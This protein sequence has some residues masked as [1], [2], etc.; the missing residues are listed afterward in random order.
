[1]TPEQVMERE[2]PIFEGLGRRVEMVDHEVLEGGIACV[3]YDVHSAHGVQR[4]LA[5]GQDG[6]VVTSLIVQTEGD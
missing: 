1:M 2:A 4:R 5:I 3:L 6:Y